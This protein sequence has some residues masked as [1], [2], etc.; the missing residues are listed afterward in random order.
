MIIWEAALNETE[1][2]TAKE[3]LTHSF[4]TSGQPQNHMQSSHICDICDFLRS[5]KVYYVLFCASHAFF[6]LQIFSDTIG[7][8]QSVS[9]TVNF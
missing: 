2:I 9:I 4:I 5:T 6:V 8:I 3:L 7:V 1:K